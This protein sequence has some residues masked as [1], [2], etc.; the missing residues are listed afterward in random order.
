[1]ITLF[2]DSIYEAAKSRPEGYLEE[3]LASGNVEGSV[4]MIPDEKYAEL[5]AKY[6]PNLPPLT[7]QGLSALAAMV[8]EAGAIALGKNSVTKEQRDERLSICNSCPEY[9]EEKRCS[10]CG[11]FMEVKTRFRTTSCPIGKWNSVN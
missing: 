5:R 9:T 7:K 1:M 2:V 11:C 4:I 6:Q 10:K 3:V 8:D